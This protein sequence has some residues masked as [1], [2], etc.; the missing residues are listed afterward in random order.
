MNYVK[1]INLNDSYQ[2]AEIDLMP[3]SERLKSQLPLEYMNALDFYAAIDLDSIT[4]R[5]LFNGS[6]LVK[7]G[8]CVL[9]LKKSII[10]DIGQL[11][12]LNYVN[13]QVDRIVYGPDGHAIEEFSKEASGIFN[14]TFTDE[15]LYE[16]SLTIPP[17]A[18]E[19]RYVAEFFITDFLSGETHIIRVPLDCNKDLW[20]RS[21]DVNLAEGDGVFTPIDIMNG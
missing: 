3:Y 16:A 6:A 21:V 18:Q 7:P 15:L 4:Q 20:I 12:L 19:G 14:Q 11:S 10:L 8:Y 1:L 9:G 17:T 2:V 13:A 5:L